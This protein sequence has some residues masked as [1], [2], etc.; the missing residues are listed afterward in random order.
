VPRRVFVTVAALIFTPVVAVISLP[1]SRHLTTAWWLETRHCRVH[2]EMDQT[3]RRHAGATTVDYDARI[4]AFSDLFDGDLDY[5]K[6]LHRVVSLSIPEAVGITD[7]GLAALSKLDDLSELNLTRLD[8]YRFPLRQDLVPFT[9][10]CV[11]HLR[12][13]PRL[14]ALTLA[15]NRITDRGL[16]QIAEMT[17]L[18]T[19]DLTA[20]EI[21]DA[22]LS[23]LQA[24]KGLQSVNLGATRVTREGI[25]KLQTAR[26]DLLIEL[27]TEPEV[28][29]GIIKRRGATQ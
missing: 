21:S 9:D 29:H 6:N 24:M 18:K 15:G 13:L 11:V 26:P 3:N 12:A 7:I 14:E 5:L 10:A 28:E 22:G 27:D 4:P 25:T 1:I 2:W 20:T 16:A 8:H 19:L 23:Y 17:S